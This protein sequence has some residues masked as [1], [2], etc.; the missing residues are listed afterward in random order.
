MEAAERHHPPEKQNDQ[1]KQNKNTP[2][3][4]QVIRACI[5]MALMIWLFTMIDWREALHAMKEGSPFYFVLAFI[6]IQL[7][8]F[9]SIIKWKMLVRSSLKGTD[10]QTPSLW[11]LGR[12]YYLGLFF[13]NFLP[14]SVGGDVVRI[15]YL[16]KRIG[17]PPAA[18]SV[19]FERLTSGGAMI[20]IVLSAALFMESVRPFLLSIFLIVGI[21]LALF[22]VFAYWMKQQGN[23]K[24][25]GQVRRF[26]WLDKIK[27]GLVKTGNAAVD[28]RRE[29]LNWWFWI[30]VHSMLFQVGMAWINQLL[31]LGFGYEISLLQLM[32]VITLIS[33]I[34][35]LPISLNGLGVRE[36]GYLFFFKSLGV[37]EEVAISVSLLFF[38]LVT[39]SSLVGG[40]FWMTERR[41]V[42]E[43]LRQQVH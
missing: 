5:S 7:T 4:K 30:A 34:T 27:A 23:S 36:A 17:M 8:V 2:L 42:D 43:A 13:N 28:Y 41:N 1:E 25:Q 12:L 32:V 3:A 26:Q 31:F 15:F 39:I 21:F 22:A 24:Q 38:I 10:Q 11:C 19:A 14:S 18:A 16:G 40:I 20:V 37:P 9:P 6:A 35:M 29:G 33:L